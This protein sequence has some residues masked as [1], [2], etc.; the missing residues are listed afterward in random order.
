[1]ADPEPFL[2]EIRM[3]GFDFAPRGWALCDGRLLPINQNQALFA[4]LGNM[5]GGNG[6][7]TF[8]LPNLQSRVP[9]GQGHGAG[10]SSY[11]VGQAGGSETVRLTAAQMPAHTHSV[12]ASGSA[13]NST[14][15]EGRVPARSVGRSY[16]ATP[17]TSTV[18][19]AN[20]LGAA[21]GGQPHA[22]VQPYLAMNFCI[23]M[24]GIFPARPDV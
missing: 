16:A 9:I 8:A 13:A 10:L 11:V 21:G 2:G 1:M 19:N 22:N 4:L 23:A 20:M 6:T 12:K 3:F 14:T 15:P 7:T 24:V 18:M 17:D 5:Y